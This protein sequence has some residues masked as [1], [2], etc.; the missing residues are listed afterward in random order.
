[1]QEQNF[2]NHTRLVPEYHFALLGIVLL[3]FILSVIDLFHGIN[4]SSVMFFLTAISLA[5]GVAKIRTFPLAVQDRAIRAEEN[6]RHFTLTG[7][8]LD[9]R[10]T[11]P[12]IIA[13]RFASD[14]EF[15]GLA[16]KAVKENLSNKQIK[17]AI[18]NWKADHHRA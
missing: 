2:K 14:E 5:L 1:M 9:S 18:Q 15:A 7:K 17:Q 10:L 16:E 6:F 13:L 12:Q 3:L 11:L 4:L 8:L